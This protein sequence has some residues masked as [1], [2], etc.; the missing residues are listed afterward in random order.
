MQIRMRKNSLTL[1]R[2]V[3]DPALKRGR[4]VTVGRLP[5]STPDIPSDIE[6]AL[7]PDEREQVQREL[8]KHH[9]AHESAGEE[10]AARQL[11][12]TI[13]RA[14]RWYDRQAAGDDVAA[15]AAASRERWSELLAAMVRAGVG[16]TRQRRKRHV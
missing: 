14:T 10:R 16:R 8:A 13:R 9:A 12:L 6:A 2:T 5:L 4:A 15:L 3:Y 1:V 11:P 7:R